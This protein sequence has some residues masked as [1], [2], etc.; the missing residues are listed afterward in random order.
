MNTL[1]VDASV[2]EEVRLE[3][4]EREEQ[5]Y[6][7]KRRHT[8]SADKRHSQKALDV[9]GLDPSQEKVMN[10]LGMNEDVGL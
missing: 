6:I 8:A 4:I 10:T 2:L 7:R 3:Q 9:L 1:G 5:A